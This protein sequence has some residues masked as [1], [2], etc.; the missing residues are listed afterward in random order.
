MGRTVSSGRG[1]TRARRA[2][3]AAALLAMAIGYVLLAG[4]VMVHGQL[5]DDRLYKDALARADAYERT[6]TEV[7]VD[8]D[9]TEATEA[10]I[11]RLRMERLD[12]ADARVLATNSLR[13]AVPPSVL[14]SGTER[15]I[16]A[17]LAYIRGDVDR[18]DAAVDLLPVLDR[19]DSVTSRYALA[20]MAARAD[21]VSTTVAEYAAALDD[22][23]ES[24]SR[25]RIPASVPVPSTGL[26]REEVG[27]ALDRVA[28][29]T[30]SDRVTVAALVAAGS[31]RDA[32]ATSAVGVLSDRV[33]ETRAELR[34]QLTGG[35]A[36][37][38]VTALAARGERAEPGVLASLNAV[39]D[40][41]AVLGPLAR[42]IGAAL[43]VAGATALVVVHR[44]DLRWAVLLVGAGAVG[45]GVGTALT[46][47]GIRW[48]V[49]PPLADATTA[50]PG[51]WDLPRALRELV[52]DVESNVT[53][54][55]AGAATRLVV[56]PMVAGLTAVA[57]V[58]L[59]AR[60]PTGSRRVAVAA[61]IS[62]AGV[63][64]VMWLLTS[65]DQRTEPCNGHVELCD[66]AYDEVVQ[67]ATHN[68]MSSPDVVKV[69]PEQD[70]TIAEQLD[71]G[72][73]GLLID[74]HYWT[75]VAS[76]GQLVDLAPGIPV[77]VV[78][79]ALA[80]Q[81]AFL[82][83]RPG[84]YLCHNHCIWG[85]VPFVDALVDVRVFLEDNP[86]EVV[87]LVIQDAISTEDT[88]EAFEAAELVPY[89]HVQPPGQRWPTLADLIDRGERLVV[90][91]EEAGPP[92][93]WYHAAFE[94]HIQDT[95]FRFRSAEELS[96]APNRGPA[97]AP[98]L[99]ANHW[100]QAVAPD[101]RN[102]AVVN[103]REVVVDRARRC[104]VERGQLPSFIAVD[105]S[106]IGDV[107]GAVDEL[108]GVRAG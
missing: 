13:W 21:R 2:A 6:Y 101:R 37:D 33:A 88:I 70:E 5:L 83:G 59:L 61:L 74:T 69:W 103:A 106:S 17:S 86:R 95:P 100:L 102:A 51:T 47:L 55:V 4:S 11:G 87:T 89:L 77:P 32:L 30:G 57:A 80:R 68:S 42:G 25:G 39:R 3:T 82:D 63:A 65:P 46:W 29:R 72:V 12:P 45:A 71:S 14:R 9:V 67:A 73:R 81:E 79:A 41:V 97:E 22:F 35:R 8:P 31:D 93:D 85:G 108:N 49:R 7:L 43:V 20:A 44:T 16:T 19:L 98:L 54:S 26:D 52:A 76:A 15:L 92:P 34:E 24:L 1:R 10:L 107:L 50:G 75:P 23:V 36:F 48:A 91:A 58:P 104:E 38:V 40:L 78:E 66:R 60:R 94:Q 56:V 99:L 90:F 105:F 53:A 96:C 27:A 64:G 28:Q 62:A 18:I 84:T